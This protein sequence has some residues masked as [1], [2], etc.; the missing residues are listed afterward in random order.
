MSVEPEALYHGAWIS[1]PSGNIQVSV[2]PRGMPLWLSDGGGLEAAIVGFLTVLA[3]AGR[4]GYI[5]G[6]RRRKGVGLVRIVGWE[7]VGTIEAANQRAQVVEDLISQGA[8]D[9][10]PPISRRERARLSRVGRR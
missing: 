4:R 6:V 1:R 5:V 8:F 7:Y 9:N 3:I 10:S 2:V